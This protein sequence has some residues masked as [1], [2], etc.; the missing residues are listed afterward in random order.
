MD[1]QFFPEHFYWGASTASHQVEGGTVN[2]WTIWELAHAKQLSKTAE[3]RLDWLP[4]YK[5]IKS[6]VED[7]Q[8]YISG[9]G[10]EHFKRYKEDYRIAKSLNLNALRFGIEWSRVEPVEGQWDEE[11]FEHYRKMI[12]EMKAKGLEP[13][14]NLWHWTMPTWFA[15]QGG[16]T[17]RGNVKFF[18]RF[19]QKIAD[20]FGHNLRHVITINE[21]NVYTTFSYLTKEWPPQ[22]GNL[23]HAAMVIWNLVLAH[24][25][26][27]KILK[28]KNSKLLVGV[29][30]QLANIQAKRPRNLFDEFSV[31]IMRYVWNWF[32]LNRIR[33]HQDFVGFNYYFSDYYTGFLKRD[34]PKVP[35]NDLG[36]YM[37]PEGLYPLLLRTWTHYKKPI[38]VTENGVADE[39]DQYRRWWL[40]ETIIAMERAISEGV[41]LKGYFHWSLLDNFEWKYGWWPKFGLVEVDRNDGMK[42][43]VRPSAVW[44]AEKIKKI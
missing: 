33:R 37:E 34:N 30:T 21:P 5:H 13:F 11:V 35:V 40:E 22:E 43:K 20:E 44:F 31:K 39:Q 41:E 15:D 4:D 17:K 32:F 25:R 9:N 29:A 1:K 18:E 24:K 3:Q 12:L 8:N 19:V 27:Y 16:F 38:F 6:K 23:L 14:L 26:A 7:P 42:R 36:W 2:Q 10:V 28:R